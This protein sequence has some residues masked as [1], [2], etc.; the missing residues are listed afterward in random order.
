MSLVGTILVAV[1]SGIHPEGSPEARRYVRSDGL[2]GDPY[3]T[4][5]DAASLTRASVDQT[6]AIGSAAREFGRNR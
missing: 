2:T 4:L 5:P 3:T 1:G 6:P